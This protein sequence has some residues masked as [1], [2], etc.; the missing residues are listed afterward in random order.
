[1]KELEAGKGMI[2][3]ISSVAVRC[4]PMLARANIYYGNLTLPN[5][6]RKHCDKTY[7]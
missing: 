5:L 2:R 3:T 7:S 1:M 4:H 6:K